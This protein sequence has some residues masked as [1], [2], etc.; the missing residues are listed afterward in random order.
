MAT[1]VFMFHSITHLFELGVFFFAKS[2]IE[3]DESRCDGTKCKWG[4]VRLGYLPVLVICMS[5]FLRNQ[6]VEQMLFGAGHLIQTFS[7]ASPVH[8]NSFFLARA[9]SELSRF[10]SSLY[11]ND[12]SNRRWQY[13]HK[14]IQTIDWLKLK[15]VMNENVDF[16][17]V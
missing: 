5:L 12:C 7:E 6:K 1:S 11:L 2:V 17:P 15:L 3:C 16:T 4:V 13:D 9:H 14:I 10:K 8:C